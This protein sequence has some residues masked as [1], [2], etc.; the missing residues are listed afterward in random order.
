MATENNLKIAEYELFDDENHFNIDSI[1]ETIQEVMKTQ[2]RILLLINDPC[3]NPTGYT[4][5]HKEWKEVIDF[6]NEVS[7]THPIVLLDD[8]AY[9][10]YAYNTDTSRKYMDIWNGLSENAMVIVSFSCSKTMTSY[11]LRCGAAVILAQK[12]EPVT[13]MKTV[14]EK[15]ARATWSNIPNAAM[16]NF[17]WV[18]NEN[19]EEFL[20]EK[21]F[22]IDLMKERSSIFLTEAHQVGLAHYPFCEGFFVT[23]KIYDNDLCKKVHEAFLENHIYTVKVN[24]GIRV[25]LCSL[26]SHKIYGLAKRMKEIED[27]ILK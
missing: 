22:Y 12:E 13:E 23:L 20:K 1:K 11:G 10:D 24:H 2:E 7:K 18:V 9:I 15:K 25:G 27:T 17:S 19:K 26:P 8:I 5:S 16:E 6:V 3:E 14:L 21:Q 4:M